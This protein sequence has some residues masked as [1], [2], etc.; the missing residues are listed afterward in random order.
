MRNPIEVIEDIHKKPESVRRSIAVAAVLSIMAI[1]VGIWLTTFSIP[2]TD[3]N[4]AEAV[5][6]ET[7]SPFSL[8]WNFVKESF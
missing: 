6:A 7:P 1:I 5:E 3:F 4:A 8:L 2:S